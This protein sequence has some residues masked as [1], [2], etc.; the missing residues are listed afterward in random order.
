M[1]I[2]VDKRDSLG[3]D[4]GVDESEGVSLDKRDGVDVGVDTGVINFALT[5]EHL[6]SALDKRE[7]VVDVHVAG[8]V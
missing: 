7:E 8:V 4:L 2:S 5:L 3:L 6:E 1:P